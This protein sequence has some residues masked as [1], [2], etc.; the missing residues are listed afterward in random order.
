M[1]DMADW[2]KGWKPTTAMPPAFEALRK[3]IAQQDQVR[4]MTAGVFEMLNEQNAATAL[5]MSSS[6]A[7]ML[8]QQPQLWQ[9]VMPSLNS[10]DLFPAFDFGRTL[11]DS[12]MFPVLERFVEQHRH[13]LDDLE[14]PHD[15]ELEAVLVEQD[16]GVEQ[17]DYLML[18]AAYTVIG[19]VGGVTGWSVAVE[20]RQA[21]I[22]GLQ[23]FLAC[24]HRIRQYLVG[25][26]SDN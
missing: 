26:E 15:E 4:S 10:T 20:D 9:S 19:L 18:V 22:V 25:L 2:F 12:P 21:T 8:K 14:L 5:T 13:L 7:Q 1:A 3:V 24:L 11:H 17:I 6:F 16:L 23:A